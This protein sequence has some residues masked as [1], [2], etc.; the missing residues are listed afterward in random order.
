VAE[1]MGFEPMGDCSPLDFEMNARQVF[2]TTYKAIA[3]ICHS[4][5]VF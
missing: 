1:G 3:S 4:L 2:S 5:T